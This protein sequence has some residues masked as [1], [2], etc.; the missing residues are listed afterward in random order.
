MAIKIEEMGT[1]T[2][3]GRITVP[4]A[5]RRA[6]G[7]EPGA[8]IVFRIENDRVTLRR[9]AVEHRD[10]ALSSFLRLLKSDI[11]RGRRIRDLP[12]GVAA[13]LRRAIK[14]M[15]VNATRPLHGFWSDL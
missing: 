10:P 13:S 9:F 6:L 15:A 1:I 4:K 7:I 2:A 12:K 5:V 3:K 14:R 11:A 8:K